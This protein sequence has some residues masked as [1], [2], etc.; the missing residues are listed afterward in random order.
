MPEHE[1]CKTYVRPDGTAVLTCP[2][3]GR[4]KTIAAEP[5]MGQK[6]KLKVKCA[7]KQ[8]FKVFLEFR[9][10]VRKKTFLKGT[11][12][13][14][15][16]KGSRSDIVI[17]DISV[18]GLTFSSL[19]EPGFKIGDELSVEFKLDDELRTDIKRDV[20]VRYVRQRLVGCEFEI[21]GGV[22]D[23]PLGNYVMS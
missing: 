11:Y 9:K 8:T 18:A 22:F 10:K 3:C 21:Y 15:S 14:H 12:I 4:Q 6:H 23:G 20:I 13:N 7:C 2:Y 16:Q 1:L 17:L 19:D 5:F